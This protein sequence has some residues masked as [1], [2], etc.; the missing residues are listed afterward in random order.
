MKVQIAEFYGLI[1]W[2]VT[3][4]VLFVDPLYLDELDESNPVCNEDEDKSRN[5]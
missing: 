2:M 5:H 3:D 1:K 4:E